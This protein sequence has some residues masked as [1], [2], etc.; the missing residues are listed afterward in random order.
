M[1]PYW[2]ED[3]VLSAGQQAVAGHAPDD[4]LLAYLSKYQQDK[5]STG[6]P[7]AVPSYGLQRASLMN[8]MRQQYPEQGYHQ[9]ITLLDRYAPKFWELILSLHFVSHEI[10]LTNNIGYDRGEVFAGLRSTQK[11]PYAEFTIVGSKL[12]RV[13]SKPNSAVAGELAKH[14]V[15]L[16]LNGLNLS[17]IADGEPHKLRHYQ[18]SDIHRAL[19]NLYKRAGEPLER[20]DLGLSVGAKTVLKDVPNNIGL[21]GVLREVFIELDRN[22]KGRG[23]ITLHK[24]RELDAEQYGRLIADLVN[25]QQP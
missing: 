14:N 25:P 8:V 16:R 3:D 24:S 7:K 15:S 22:A 5:L 9:T 11:R 4:K 19:S 23:T 2:D 20:G 18:K 12:K 1:E 21:K 6:T 10:E 17:L 13:I